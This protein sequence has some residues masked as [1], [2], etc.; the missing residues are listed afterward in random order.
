MQSLITLSE[1]PLD[2][3]Q[4]RRKVH[5][6]RKFS[7]KTIFN[8]FINP[9]RKS[10]RR[11]DDK[12]YAIL[13]NYGWVEMLCAIALLV[14]SFTDAT[15][16]LLLIDRGGEE[17]NP[18]MNY[19]LQRGTSEFIAVKMLIPFLTVFFFIAS[20]NFLFCSL[21]RTRNIMFFCLL[22]YTVLIAYELTLLAQAYP[23][24]FNFI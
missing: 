17:L 8:G 15:F 11:V 19:F 20:W 2:Y 24:V 5:N 3:V 4:P 13:D 18:V 1:Q 14:F 6:R 7:T 23:E 9:R 21:F 10:N 12:P 22:I 16:T